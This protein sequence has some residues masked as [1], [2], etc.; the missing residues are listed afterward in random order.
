VAALPVT[1]KGTVSS[2]LE[3]YHVEWG[4]VVTGTG[5]ISGG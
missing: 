1:I 2:G 3:S 5:G 4:Y